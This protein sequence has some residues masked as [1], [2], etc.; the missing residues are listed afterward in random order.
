MPDGMATFAGW[1][2]GLSTFAARLIPICTVFGFAYAG[3]VYRWGDMINAWQDMPE[4]LD[5]LEERLG[6]IVPVP[7]VELLPTA[8]MSPAVVRAAVAVRIVFVLRR[9][10]ACAMTGDRQFQRVSAGS[11]DP[12]LSSTSRAA[13]PPLTLGYEVFTVPV[14]IPETIAP[15]LY[16]YRPILRWKDEPPISTPPTFFEVVAD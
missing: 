13:T 7:F 5:R 4:R 8:R 16:A 15:G 12:P 10:P 6:E 11:I 1:W 14:A 9:N 3:A 2:R